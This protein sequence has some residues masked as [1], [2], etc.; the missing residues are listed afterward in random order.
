MA[1]LFTSDNF[2]AEA[3]QS[4]LPVMIDFYAD[5]CGPCKMMMP[6]VEKMAEQY[7]GKIK[8]GKVNVET[9]TEL[10]EKYGV[11]N[12]PTF[13]FLKNGEAVS[14]SVGGMRA[15]VLSAKLDE[16]IG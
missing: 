2:E 11:Q 12:I 6:I 3:L 15:D 5:W 8:I 1:I 4:E 13:V 14:T 16:L 10:A 7:E 9:E